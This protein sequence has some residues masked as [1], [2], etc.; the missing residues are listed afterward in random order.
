MAYI[1]AEPVPGQNREVDDISSGFNGNATAF[2][3]QVSSVNVSP[4][5][6]NNILVNLGGVMQNP[7]TDYTIAASTITFT[8][9]PAS[10]L[11]F[12]ALI[13]G[14]GINTATVADQTIGPSKLLNTAVTAGS[15]TTADITVDAQGRVTAAANGTISTAELADSTGT[16]DG[17]TTAKLADQAVTNA[18]VNNSAAIAGTKISPDFGSQNIVT[19]GSISGAAG[20]LTGDLTIP[21]TIVHTGDSDTKIRFSAADTVSV[22]TAGAQRMQIAS[23]GDQ[24][25]TSTAGNA[26][27]T[28]KKGNAPTGQQSVTVKFD[29]NGT[30]LG[31]VGAPTQMTG[32]NGG[33]MAL[34]AVNGNTLRFGTGTGGACTEKV[35]IDQ[36]GH[37]YIQ[38][39]DLVISTNG[40]GIN[41]AASTDGSGTVSAELLDDYEEGTFDVNYKTGSGGGNTLSAAAYTSTGG[42]YTKIGNMVHFAIRI[43]T[44]SHTAVG[45][46]IVIEGLPF[47]QAN[48]TI[49]SGAY[50]TLG[51]MLGSSPAYLHIDGTEIRFQTQANANFGSGAGGVNFNEQF[52]CAGTY[53]AA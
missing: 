11:S 23:D 45:G 4:E 47:T 1:G 43:K 30:V 37:L 7:G 46:Q 20:T 9:A 42:V 16:T 21:D 33:D 48:G 41:F 2:T 39:G 10:G 50:T 19:T 15:Y 13:L 26:S 6:A 32:G 40:H 52:H 25:F 27:F 17:V 5:S 51:A 29:R 35:S 31:G 12:W 44:S 28:F 34:M 38:D 36:N 22:E 18:K 49:V 24:T 53:T 8:T 3:L 14:A